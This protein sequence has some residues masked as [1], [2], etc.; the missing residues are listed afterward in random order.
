MRT[1]GA[2]SLP[3]TVLF[4]KNGREFGRA[5]G[6]QPWDHP[7]AVAYLRDMADVE[8]GQRSEGRDRR[9]RDRGNNWRWITK[10]FRWTH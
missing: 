8:V 9:E 4:D 6:P 3:L 5:N 2:Y 7:D 10:M 1:F